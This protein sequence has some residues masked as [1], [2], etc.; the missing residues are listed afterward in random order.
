MGDVKTSFKYTLLKA[1]LAAVAVGYLAYVVKP[2]DMLA[3]VASA[4]PAWIGAALLLL[5]VNLLLETVGWHRLVS[6]VA[7]STRWRTAA[8]SLLAGHTLGFI[9]P[10]GLGAY[11]G[12]AYALP[13]PRRGVL[14]ALVY[15]DRLLA[16]LIGVTAGLLGFLAYL[17][18][19]TPEPAAMWLGALMVGAVIVLSLSAIL[20]FPR[21][22]YRLVSRVAFIRRFRHRLR[23]LRRYRTTAM[24]GL[25]SLATVR[26]AVYTTQFVLLL[27]A[28]SPDL[29]VTTAYLGVSAVFFAKYLIPPVTLMDLGIREGA[30]VFFLGAF[31]VSQAI[32]FDAAFL[33][34]CINLL[35]PALFGVPFVFSLQLGKKPGPVN[36]FQPTAS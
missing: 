10:A 24:V 33:L 11:A 1:I 4:R 21:L 29:P 28:F 15:T 2:A 27:Y 7:P 20:L 18:V 25:I 8:A 6:P 16:M 26:Y 5:P 30:A 19:A 13:H 3:A 36:V 32:S 17:D 9:S 35:G 12:R 14:M 23:F 31:G 22:S 34:F